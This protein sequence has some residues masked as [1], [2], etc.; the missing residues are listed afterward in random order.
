MEHYDKYMKYKN[1][2]LLLK[3]N[4][5]KKNNIMVGGMEEQVPQKLVDRDGND[6][7]PFILEIDDDMDED[8]N[9]E[10]DDME[11]EENDGRK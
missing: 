7:P 2:Y 9:S 3:K 8:E 11:V 6:I 4:T 1:K 5:I 10:N